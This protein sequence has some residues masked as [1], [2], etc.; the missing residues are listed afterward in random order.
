LGVKHKLTIMIIKNINQKRIDVPTNVG[1]IALKDSASE[2]KM[3]CYMCK[4]I[5]RSSV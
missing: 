3:K 5:Y 1:L 4:K 2:N